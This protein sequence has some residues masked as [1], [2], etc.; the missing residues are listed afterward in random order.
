MNT[1]IL[2]LS[3]NLSHLPPAGN[4]SGLMYEKHFDPYT[5]I[6]LIDGI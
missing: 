2:P 4:E 1:L 3:M 5:Q 6:W